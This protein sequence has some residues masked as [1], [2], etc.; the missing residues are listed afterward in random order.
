MKYNIITDFKAI[1]L[2]NWD[3]FVR[4]HANGNIFQTPYIYNVYNE[5][6]NFKPI[7]IL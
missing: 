6:P 5:T 1:D 4:N 2:N 7:G 3:K